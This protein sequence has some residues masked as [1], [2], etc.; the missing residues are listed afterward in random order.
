MRFLYCIPV[1]GAH[2]PSV[3]F[4]LA[5]LWF[6]GS[7]L[8]SEKCFVFP[9]EVGLSSVTSLPQS[10]GTTLVGEYGWQACEIQHC[11][12]SEM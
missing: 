10:Q 11:P 1:G 8:G 2:T 3:L 7:M 12:S 4:A 9:G 6:L 5:L